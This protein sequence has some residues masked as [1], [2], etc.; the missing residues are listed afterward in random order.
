VEPVLRNIRTFAESS[1]VEI[2]TPLA[3]EVTTEVLRE[4]GAFIASVDR[5]IPWHLMR[6]F[7][8]HK[9]E[10]PEAYDFDAS[11]GFL[12]EIRN[13]LPYVYFGSFPGSDWAD[14]LC[15]DCGEKMIRRISIGA[16]RMQFAST[17][18]DGGC[19]SACGAQIPLVL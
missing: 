19:C 5:R 13:E 17:R 16:C 10:N 1:H 15:P 14:T 18:M 6:L 4:I 8:A 3:N 7:A 2:V 11:I 9:Q 12:K